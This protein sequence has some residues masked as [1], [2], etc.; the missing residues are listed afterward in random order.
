MDRIQN[1]L[2]EFRGKGH[3]QNVT[4]LFKRILETTQVSKGHTPIITS[5]FKKVQGNQKKNDSSKYNDETV[6][7]TIMAKFKIQ[8]IS[9]EEQQEFRKNKSTTDAVFFMKQIKE[10]TIEYN[11]PESI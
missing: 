1:Q 6:H 2:L 5:I 9:R 3:G 11:M 7:S 10:E 8:I 4:I